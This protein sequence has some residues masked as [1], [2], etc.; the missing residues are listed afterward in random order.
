MSR[1]CSLTG[2]TWL[3]GNN[4]SHSNRKTKRRFMPNLHKLTLTS[5]VLG[6]KFRMKITA[7]TLRT[8]DFKGGFDNFLLKTKNAKLTSVALKLKKRILK[9]TS[10]KDASANLQTKG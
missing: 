9:Q 4:V 5:E 8:I 1:S 10:C 2:H 7:K 6:T 3:N